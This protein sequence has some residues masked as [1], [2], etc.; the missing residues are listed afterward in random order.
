MHQPT[1]LDQTCVAAIYLTKNLVWYQIEGCGC[2]ATKF[3]PSNTAFISG[4]NQL[5]IRCPLLLLCL[6]LKSLHKKGCTPSY[7]ASVKNHS[8]HKRENAAYTYPV[9]GP[10]FI[11]YFLDFILLIHL[12][13]CALSQ[14]CALSGILW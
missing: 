13:P 6:V 8:S 2:V 14:K 9:K 12:L 11:Y 1:D 4:T 7:G 10:G 5:T 3:D